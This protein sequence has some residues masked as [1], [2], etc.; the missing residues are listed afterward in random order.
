MRQRRRKHSTAANAARGRLLAEA[1]ALDEIEVALAVGGGEV[2]Q[3][4][5]ALADEEQQAAARGV[6]SLVCA[7]VLLKFCDTRRD[8]RNLHFGGTGVLGVMTAG[9][10]GRIAHGY[11]STLFACGPVGDK[12]EAAFPPPSFACGGREENSGTPCMA[13]RGLR[14]GIWQWV[15]QRS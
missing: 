11:L 8:G 9:F 14:V 4:S 6:I 5:I 7:E 13:A 3:Q 10:D 15:R 2:L 1:E 12:H